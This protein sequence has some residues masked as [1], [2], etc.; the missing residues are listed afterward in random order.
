MQQRGRKSI[1][2]L[3][4]ITPLPT[5]MLEPPSDLNA[6]EASVWARTAATKPLDWW[7]AGSA[8]LLA[9]FSRAKVQSDKIAALMN[10]SMAILSTDPEE[11]G[12]YDKL[13]KVQNRLSS[14]LANLATKMRLTQQSRYNAKSGDTASRR[15]SGAR[16]W[17]NDVIES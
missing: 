3:E 17:H 4:V 7:D 12:R 6:E 2:S 1:S 13:Q 15:A 5:R 8:P 9:Q 10:A 14:E 16:P 11:L